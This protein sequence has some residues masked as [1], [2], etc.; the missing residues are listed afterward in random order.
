VEENV[1][2]DAEY[3]IYELTQ[4]ASRRNFSEFSEILADMTSKGY[5]ENAALASLTS[6]FRTLLEVSTLRGSD[7]EIATALGIKPYAVQRNRETA[8]RLGR[9]RVKELYSRLYELSCG[10]RSGLYTKSGAL[11]AAI[12]QLFFG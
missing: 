10:A 7:S 3:K 9:G 11:S 4:A 1:A 6:H 5:D 8:S 2:K 12:A